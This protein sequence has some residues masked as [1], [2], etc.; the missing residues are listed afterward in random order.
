ML[1]LP[2]LAVIERHKTRALPFFG[3]AAALPHK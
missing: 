2:V 3:P 1:Q